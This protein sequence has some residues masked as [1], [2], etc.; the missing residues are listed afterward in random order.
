M[1]ST[2]VGTGVVNANYQIQKVVFGIWVLVS[3]GII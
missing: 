1:V 3:F 2:I